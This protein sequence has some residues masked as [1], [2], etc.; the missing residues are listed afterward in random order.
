MAE[1][2]I[3]GYEADPLFNDSEMPQP[4]VRTPEQAHVG[5]PP[6]ATE[7]H[8][9]ADLDAPVSPGPDLPSGDIGPK[10]IVEVTKWHPFLA[11]FA[12]YAYSRY[13]GAATRAEKMDRAATQYKFFY[14]TMKVCDWFFLLVMLLALAVLV[15]WAVWKLLI[16]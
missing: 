10:W 7:R 4:D 15:T 3:P 12:A 13:S 6:T 9:N 14:A 11:L 2:S 1:S 16:K 8:G 5:A